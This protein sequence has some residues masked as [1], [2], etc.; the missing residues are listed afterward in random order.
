MLYDGHRPTVFEVVPLRTDLNRLFGSRG[1]RRSPNLVQGVHPDFPGAEA[2]TENEAEGAVNVNNR[3]L[4]DPLPRPSVAVGSE[5]PVE[6][7]YLFTCEPAEPDPAQMGNDVFLD[8][9]FVSLQR[10]L[11]VVVRCHVM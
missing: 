10:P 11:T 7:L 4:G 8:A 3:L 9:D 5:L 1:S 2:P 6:V